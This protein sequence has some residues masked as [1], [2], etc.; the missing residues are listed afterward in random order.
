VPDV[1]TADRT[2]GRL[3]ALANAGLASLLSL[4]VVFA[5]VQYAREGRNWALDFGAG[6]ALSVVAVL[7]ERHRGWAA[8]AG[9][10]LA[11]A[12]GV[13]ARLGQLPG[14]PGAAAILALLVLGGAAVR[15]LPPRAAIGVAAAGAAMLTAGLLT[16]DRT[17]PGMP[18]RLGAQGWCFALGIGLWLRFLDYRRTVIDDRVRRD[19]RVDL[20]REL[21]DLVAHHVTGIVLQTQGARIVA[22]SHP[23]RLDATLAGIEQAGTEALAAMRRVVG[24][25][26]D[27][28]D[29][30][31]TAP[32]P[33]QLTELVRR[34]D[35]QRRPAGRSGADGRSDGYDGGHSDDGHN[36]D[37]AGPGPSVRLRLP[38]QADQAAWPPELTTTVYRIVQESLTNIAR[39]AA[40]AR[41]AT[42]DVSQD[43]WAVTVE[44]TDDAAPASPRPTR[45]PRQRG[46]GLV[47]MG[48][49]V[50]A[51]GGTFRAGP[52][53]GAGWSV[54]ASLPC[55]AGE[56][57]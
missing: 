34:F 54:R 52:A 21:H 24:L 48:E 15:T 16:A 11:G 26:R 46:F 14:E 36:D 20:A 1:E 18:F 31:T 23:E 37:D 56:R 8:V 49:R 6:T 9:L 32:G 43:Q 51:L 7:R 53:P 39:H 22:R 17:Y 38:D 2:S 25:L 44:V 10:A 50:E 19:E 29:G 12:A 47:G 13:A 55:R 33:E 35:R 41:T 42:V 3:A 5:A 4:V 28:D 45:V 30:A 57:R 40:H 27:A